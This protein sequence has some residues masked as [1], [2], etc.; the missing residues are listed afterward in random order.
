MSI[1]NR[2]RLASVLAGTL[3]AS[4]LAGVLALEMPNLSGKWRLNRDASDSPEKV[5]RESPADG[6]SAGG[7]HGGGM[8]HGGG[9]HRSRSAPPSDDGGSSSNDTGF[10]RD[11][12]GHSQTLEIRHQEPLL[13]IT[14][15]SG[16]ERVLYTDGRKIEKEHS[17]TGTTKVRAFWK[18]GRIEVTSVP[19][20]GPKVTETFAMTADRT[21]LTVATT[22]ARRR[23]GDVTI[24]R[25]YDAVPDEKSP[26]SPVAAP[27][28]D[29]DPE[30]VR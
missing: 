25:I 18:D 1:A 12:L 5:L 2:I 26:S 30:S 27:G 9:G 23:G 16:R 13:S 29:P 8:G 14:D 7:F 10:L 11:F 6:R 19:D 17:E 3:L 28:A 20:K 4:G 15:S 22:I 24:R 21:Q